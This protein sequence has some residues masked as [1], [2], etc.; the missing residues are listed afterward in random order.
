MDNDIEGSKIADLLFPNVKTSVDFYEGKYPERKIAKIAKV[1]RFGPSPTGFLHIGSLFSAL[2]SE[3]LAHQSDG[4]FFLRIEDTD[5]KREVE[6]GVKGITLALSRFNIVIDE[7]FDGNNVEYGEYGPYKQSER[8]EIYHVFIKYLIAKRYAYPCFCS[9]EEL[10]ATHKI[11]EIQKI[12]PGY[13][14]EWAVHKKIT[15]EEISK[16]ISEGKSFVIRL[17]SDGSELNKMIFTDLIKGEVTL[18]ENDLDVILLKTDGLPT[19]HF[20]HVVDD[21]LMKT[22]HVIRGDEWLSSLPIHLQI[23]KYFE[24]EAPFFGHISPI[25]KMD[26]GSKRKL[27]KRKDPEAAIDYYL[28]QGYPVNAV[29]EYLLNIANSDFEDWRRKNPTLPSDQFK[30]LLEKFSKS[31]ALFDITKLSDTSKEIIS[32]LSVDE[33]YNLIINWTN[34]YDKR[35]ENILSKNSEYTKNILSIERNNEKPRKDISK[36]LEVKENIYYFF[37]DLFDEHTS[38]TPIVFPELISKENVKKII[39]S[40]IEFYDES[41]NKQEWFESLKNFAEKYDFARDI[42]I[43]KQN[44]ALFNGH[45][46]DVAM[47]IRIALTGKTK[48]LDLFEMMRVMGKDFVVSRLT[49]SVNKI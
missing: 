28:E 39:L 23:F 49:N 18:T 10:E 14:G 22:T 31:G 48:T 36:W 13:Y 27:S 34:I 6:N 44:P 16:N 40:Y 3:R 29:I 9:P 46:G 7:G 37:N 4:I 17:K 42:K 43:Y 26:D 8:R 35:L 30:I 32:L 47:I 5:K 21:H 15:F 45:V 19:Y 11:Q 12:R 1:T 20:A 2:V 38:T 33:M 25:L 41:Q 24:W